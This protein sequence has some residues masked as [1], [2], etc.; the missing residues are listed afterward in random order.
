MF[1]DQILLLIALI[2]VPLPLRLVAWRSMSMLMFR[3]MPLRPIPLPSSLLQ[4]RM[5]GLVLIRPIAMRIRLLWLGMV[6]LM[7]VSMFMRAV[8]RCGYGMPD[9]LTLLFMSFLEIGVLLFFLL[10]LLLLLFRLCLVTMRSP[11]RTGTMLHR[12]IMVIVIVI[13]VMVMIILMFPRISL[14]LG[15]RSRGTRFNRRRITWLGPRIW[16]TF[17]LI[18]VLVLLRTPV[19]IITSRPRAFYAMIRASEDF[20]VLTPC[21]IYTAP[22]SAPSSSLYRI[23]NR[24]YPN[25]RTN[26]PPPSSSP[27]TPFAYSSPAPDPHPSPSCTSRSRHYYTTPR[28][29]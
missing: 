13:V 12:C 3:L 27:H 9:I 14:T 10:L 25:H 28:R 18:I 15:V 2:L 1:N 24:T 8:A 11:M 5:M 20:V 22:S 7:F 21:F 16:T 26:S 4:S 6:V 29:S 19:T 17:M 23:N